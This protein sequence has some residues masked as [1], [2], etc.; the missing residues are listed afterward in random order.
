MRKI[1]TKL[2]LGLLIG[3]IV[4]TGAVFGVHHFQYGR[5][6]DSLRWQ[7]RRAEEQGQVK[8][9]AKYLQ[10]YLEFNPKDLEEKAH[11]A[12]LWASDTFAGSVRERRKAVNLLDQVLTTGDDK[13]ELRRLLVKM[14]L[15][16]QQFKMAHN[17]L[18]KL[19]SHEFLKSPVDV[20]AAGAKLDAER[21]ESEGYA[22][23]LLEA[24]NQPAKALVCYRLA[25]KHAPEVQSNYLNL[26]LLL[27]KQK[28]LTA[29]KIKANQD[30]A[31]GVINE[32]VKNNRLSHEAYLTRW[33]YRRDFGLIDSRKDAAAGKVTLKVAAGDV[34]EALQRAQ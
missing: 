3:C 19:L 8:Q 17:H 18:E 7:A 28:E 34:A 10:R 30:D 29:D 21:G 25:V 26:A 27:R 4:C 5:I 15:E 12:K 33:R 9:Q 32:L 6:A 20:P 31:D 14:A 16:V 22:G 24:E 11:L 1:N 2:V 23:Q 13:P